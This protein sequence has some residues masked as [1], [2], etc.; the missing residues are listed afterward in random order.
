[1]RSSG[2]RRWTG[3]ATRRFP[4]QIAAKPEGA[5]HI[6][7]AEGIEPV[8]LQRLFG[9]AAGRVNFARV[10]RTII[11]ERVLEAGKGQSG[12]GPSELWR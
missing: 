1:M 6:E 9:K 4:G 2:R 11:Q 10:I 12:I 5:P 8:Q 7:L 3:Q